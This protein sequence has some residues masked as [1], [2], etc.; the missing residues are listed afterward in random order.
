MTWTYAT[1]VNAIRLVTLLFANP[2]IATVIQRHLER[3][4]L[5]SSHERDRGDFFSK[6]FC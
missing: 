2:A 1:H 6:K 4:L 5:K 3:H